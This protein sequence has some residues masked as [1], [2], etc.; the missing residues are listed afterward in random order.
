MC[1]S[2]GNWFS[3]LF[4]N[5]KSI[6]D[7]KK[8]CS[9]CCQTYDVSLKHCHKCHKSYSDKDIHCD[10]C[11]VVY[12]P[13]TTFHCVSCHSYNVNFES[14]ILCKNNTTTKIFQNNIFTIC[15]EN[16]DDDVYTVNCGHIY[17]TECISEWAKKNNSCP[18][19]RCDM[20]IAILEVSEFPRPPVMTK[21]PRPQPPVTRPQVMTEFSQPR[22]TWS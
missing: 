18:L 10:K 9:T 5:R 3:R 11:C 12:N 2:G 21:F 4:Y 1:L 16:I 6:G 15:M 19:C 20:N 14:C 22:V 17:H 7:R 13:R 8:H